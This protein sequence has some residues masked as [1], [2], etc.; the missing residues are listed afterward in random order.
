MMASVPGYAA[1]GGI[2]I[3]KMGLLAVLGVIATGAFR[4]QVTVKEILK[5]QVKLQDKEIG[6]QQEVL[7]MVGLA[8]EA[9]ETAIAITDVR[10]GIVWSNPAMDTLLYNKDEEAT[11]PSLVR[12]LGMEDK[13]AQ[14]L[15][16]CVDTEGPRQME[17]ELT[18][19]NI[20]S[21]SV[22]PFTVSS[23]SVEKGFRSKWKD[24][25]PI[26]ASESSD[27][28]RFLVAFNDVSEVRARERAEKAASHEAMQRQAMSES[29]ET[30]CTVVAQA[31]LCDLVVV[32]AV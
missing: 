11:F 14:L 29:M 26:L 3:S 32:T 8:L 6:Q 17:V 16:G 18:P 5:T 7:H 13:E 15:R 24:T 9:S 21:V 12:S 22:S 19:G 30:V 2:N 20:F 1:R 4:E 31:A 10:H 23:G 25:D 27:N 28:H